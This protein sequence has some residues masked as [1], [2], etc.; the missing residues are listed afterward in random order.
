MATARD[1][2]RLAG[3]STA[4]V[5]YVFNDGP[6]PVAAAT[7]E[8]VLA[9]AAELGYLPNALARS[10]S[11]GRTHS[12]GLI[13]PDI[14]NPYFAELARAIEDVAAASGNLLLIADSAL[15]PEQE[16]RHR[17]S[18]IERQVDGA[19]VISVSDTPD[20][21]EFVA[22]S[23]PVVVLHP[24]AA[25]QAASS[26]TIDFVRAA[27]YATRHL[28][29]HGYDSLALLIGPTDSVGAGEHRVGFRRALGAHPQVS[30]AE[31]RSPISRFAAA[32]EAQRQLSAAT[33]PR[34]IYCST[35]EQAFGVLFAAH[36][37]GLR[38]PEDLAVVGFDGTEN[39][40]VSIPALTTVHQP[41]R[42]YAERA[43]QLLVEHQ[44]GD[45]PVHEMLE[46]EF[47]IRHSCGCPTAVSGT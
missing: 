43:V 6:R 4:V 29:E 40:Q 41:R 8:R 37:L 34:A 13:V 21:A 46:W 25:R 39:C 1:V 28:L 2:A 15:S 5:S 18:L 20:F 24:I 42:A 14:C 22:A 12:L 10:L 44:P 30:A 23:T 38:V 3:T 47:V 31:W 45:D 35:D 16:A 17:R 32:Q 11:A 26:L 19:V 33:R 7:R 36:C 27:E 9:A